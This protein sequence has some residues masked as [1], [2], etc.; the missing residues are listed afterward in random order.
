MKKGTTFVNIICGLSALMLFVMYIVNKVVIVILPGGSLL[1]LL[2]GG[3][4]L[5]GLF[6]PVFTGRFAAV[7][8]YVCGIA[9]AVQIVFVGTVLVALF[10]QK[11]RAWENQEVKGYRLPHPSHTLPRNSY[12]VVS[13]EGRRA[14]VTSY[15]KPLDELVERYGKGFNDLVLVDVTA[16]EVLPRVYVKPHATII[17]P[18]R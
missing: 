10:V 7:C 11:E 14:F 8:K 1:F 9:L 15:D 2:A 17:E 16:T 3:G 13:I 5:L 6:L 12:L 4:L 18:T